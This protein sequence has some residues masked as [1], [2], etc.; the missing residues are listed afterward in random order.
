LSIIQVDTLQKRDGSTFPL[1]KIGQVVNTNY[2]GISTTTS[3]TPADVSGFS[4]TI[5]PSLTSSKVLVMVTVYF[6]GVTNAYNYILCQR[7][8][9]GGATT[10]IGLGVNASGN[11]INTFLS[12]GQNQNTFHFNE[13]S[14]NILDTPSTTSAITYQIQHA[15]PYSSNTG[16]INRIG[17]SSDAVYVQ[18]PSSTITLM[19]VLA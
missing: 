14:K 15:Q 8:I 5:T 10:S 18:S 2:T 16:Y 9:S 3:A 17:D 6:G 13:Y 11:Q 7:Q 19:E 4:A 1:G 12:N